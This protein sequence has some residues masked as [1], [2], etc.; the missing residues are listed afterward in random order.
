MIS[1]ARIPGANLRDQA[2]R[3]AGAL[4]ELGVTTLM[5][6]PPDAL[7]TTLTARGTDLVGALLSVSGGRLIA[8]S[9][10]VVISIASD[11]LSWSAS[12]TASAAAWQSALSR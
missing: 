3:T 1:A 10:G 5:L 7:P 12:D 6:E 4:A 9:I 2:V 8:D 11:G